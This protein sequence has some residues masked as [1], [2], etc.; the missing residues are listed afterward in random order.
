MEQNLLEKRMRGWLYEAAHDVIGLW[1]LC[2]AA[3]YDWGVRSPE[4]LKALVL[5]FVRELLANGVQAINVSDLQPWPDQRPDSVTERISREW[6]ALGREPNV[7]D[8]VWFKKK[9]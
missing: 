2:H 1:N 6:D 3:R 8:I 4:E 9:S 7:P 5:G